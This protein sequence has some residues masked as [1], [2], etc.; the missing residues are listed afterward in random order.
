LKRA[1]QR[2]RLSPTSPAPPPG[3]LRNKRSAVPCRVRYTQGVV[4]V[5]GQLS[6][7]GLTVLTSL[8]G[9][10]IIGLQIGLQVGRITARLDRIQRDLERHLSDAR[11]D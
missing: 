2:G 6:D 3:T 11:H 4:H 10:A 7:A 5:L 8:A 1:S 9:I